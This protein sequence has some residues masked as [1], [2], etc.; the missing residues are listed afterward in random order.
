MNTCKAPVPCINQ[1]CKNAP[2]Y[3]FK[4][5]LL[6]HLTRCYRFEG[7]GLQG[8]VRHPKDSPGYSL[9]HKKPKPEQGKIDYVYHLKKFI[10]HYPEYYRQ[11][12]ESQRNFFKP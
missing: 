2:S 3:F 11:K 5:R 1:Y 10:K 6:V 8:I 7:N 12:P 9:M 4:E